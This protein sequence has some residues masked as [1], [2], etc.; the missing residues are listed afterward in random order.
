MNSLSL[1]DLAS[2][3][4]LQKRGSALKTEISR[5]TQEL[6]SGQVADVKSVLAGNYGYLTDIETGL[7]T[8]QGYKVS[9]TEAAQFAGTVQ[10]VLETVQE[11]TSDFGTDLIMVSSGGLD[12]VAKQSGTEALQ[13]LKSTM[14][15]LN[16]NQSGRSLFSGA[17]TNQA[18]FGS[19]DDLMT[20]LRSVVTGI[21][22]ATA[23]LNA[24]ENWFNDA[25]GFDAVIYNGSETGLSAFSLSNSEEITL[26]IKGTD[27]NL[28]AT[29]MNLAV[30]A[31]SSDETLNVGSSERRALLLAAGQG[32]FQA[33]DGL[34]AL[35]AQVGYS[36][37]RIENIATRNASES[38]SLEYA[39]GTL[40]GADPYETASRLEEVQFQLQSLYA[41]TVK[42]SQL[43]LVNFL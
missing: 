27:P 28:K 37:E 17:A 40:L 38:L 11:S 43:S 33:Q 3:F 15:A 36:E 7:S 34:T 1:G 10:S 26:D 16:T 31:I 25:S 35:R 12:N 19:A 29:L 32:L 18:S 39:K 41:V 23:K 5:L 24:I 8:L 9:T 4:M 21:S 14:S 22:G 42:T 20:E 6:T 30:A 2:S 13:V